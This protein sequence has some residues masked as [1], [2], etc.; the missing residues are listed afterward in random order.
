MNA[1]FEAA[2]KTLA[3][4][5]A[6]TIPAAVLSYIGSVYGTQVAGIIGCTI[7]IGF[8]IY[9]IY[10]MMLGQVESERRMAE[11]AERIVR[12]QQTR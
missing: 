4:L 5:G 6:M 2:L 12:M 11:A 3:V 9:M 8:L 1:K 7:F 10:S